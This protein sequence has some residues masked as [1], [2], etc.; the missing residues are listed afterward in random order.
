MILP[1]T[2]FDVK[3]GPFLYHVKYSKEVAREGSCFGCTH[4]N[5]QEIYLDPD[6]KP[7]KLKQTLLHEILHACTFVNG[8][9]YRFDEKENR[10]PTEEEVV[11]KLSMT[12][13]EVMEDNRWLFEYEEVAEKGETGCKGLRG[14]ATKS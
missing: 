2:E 5:E 13:H 12:L 3:V 6:V 7:Q 9:V 14:K 8:L 10:L 1:T 11:W 4:N